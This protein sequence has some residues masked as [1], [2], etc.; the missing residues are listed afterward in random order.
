MSV[1]PRHP[2]DPDQKRPQLTP[3]VT[4]EEYYYFVLFNV[5]F[6]SGK[7]CLYLC[8]CLCLCLLVSMSGGRNPKHYFLS[9]W[10]LIDKVQIHVSQ[11]V[12]SNLEWQKTFGNFTICVYC[13]KNRLQCTVYPTHYNINNCLPIWMDLKL[14]S[15]SPSHIFHP[16]GT[17]CKSNITIANNI[18]LTYMYVLNRH[19]LNQYVLN[20]QSH[21]QHDSQGTRH[22]LQTW[23]C[24]IHTDLDLVSVASFLNGH[25]TQLKSWA[26]KVK[27]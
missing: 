27:V 1:P 14:C 8:L 20:R 3:L 19:V 13:Y 21:K 23:S 7:G 22:V 15:W 24:H 25:P 16:C 5:S 9:T 10:I 26:T 11:L 17:L 6:N 12:S 18:S 4:K 2:S